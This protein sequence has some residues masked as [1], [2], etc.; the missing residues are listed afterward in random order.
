MS[1]VSVQNESLP[2]F[3]P[4]NSKNISNNAI[5]Q[6]R[7]RVISNN[8]ES[9]AIIKKKV[10]AM[11]HELAPVKDVLSVWINVSMEHNPHGNRASYSIYFNEMD[12]RNMNEIIE[13]LHNQPIDYVYTK[14]ILQLLQLQEE[15]QPLC[16]YITSQTVEQKLKDDNTDE[17]YMELKNKIKNRIGTVTIVSTSDETGQMVDKITS[18][19]ILNSVSDNKSNMQAEDVHKTVESM[20][21][22][23]QLAVKE[24][25]L[26]D[27]HSS[28]ISTETSTAITQTSVAITSTV[29]AETVTEVSSPTAESSPV[30]AEVSQVIPRDTNIKPSYSYCMIQ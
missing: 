12:G 2:T 24:V 28:V 11:Q 10:K 4:I 26:S 6:K 14:V 29:I 23:S 9:F 8:K 20:S 22:V 30:I 13:V 17:L 18:D 27:E 25:P 16:I 15:D 21:I 19:K 7:K 1:K 3:E 5:T